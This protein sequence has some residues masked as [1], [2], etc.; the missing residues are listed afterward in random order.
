MSAAPAMVTLTPGSRPPLVS[1]AAPYTE[2]VTF[3]AAAP[4]ATASRRTAQPSAA[5]NERCP[6]VTR[7]MKPPRIRRRN[8]NDALNCLCLND[9]PA[10]ITGVTRCRQ[11]NRP[12]TTAASDRSDIFVPL[13]TGPV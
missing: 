11:E 7:A 6:I 13:E 2:P 9:E 12:R 5:R 4:A 3:C 10:Y 1:V 8:D